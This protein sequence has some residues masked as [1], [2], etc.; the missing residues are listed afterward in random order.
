MDQFAEIQPQL[1]EI[2]ARLIELAVSGKVGAGGE[3]DHP[4]NPLGADM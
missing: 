2:A 1:T 3:Q 4:R